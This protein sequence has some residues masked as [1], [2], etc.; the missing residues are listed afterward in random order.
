MVD[1]PTVADFEEAFGLTPGAADDQNNNQSGEGDN[2][3]QGTGDQNQPGT[4]N[5]TPPQVNED[6][7]TDSGATP[8]DED[9][10]QTP[11]NEPPKPQADDKDSKA[12]A[13]MRVENN[14]MRKSIGGLAETLGLNRNEPLDTLL[15][16]VQGVITQARA[17]QSGIPAALL[18]KVETLE[19]INNKYEQEHRTVKLHEGLTDLAE[20]YKLDEKA[21][22]DFVYG[23]AAEGKNPMLTDVDVMQEYESRNFDKII[24]SKVAAAVLAEQQRAANASNHSNPPNGHQAPGVDTPK[25]DINSVRELDEFF[26]GIQ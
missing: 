18:K 1:I 9:K 15:P 10:N 11:P 19:E 7:A 20:K 25:K 3:G 13:A 2:D 4:D 5:Q 6:G 14:N 16:K 24:E 17:K 21:L 23:L 22:T 12:F 26:N 8:P